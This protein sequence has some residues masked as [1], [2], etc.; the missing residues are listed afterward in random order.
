MTEFREK[1]VPYLA[2]ENCMARLER[3]NRRAWMVVVILI[4]A[5]LVTNFGWIYYEANHTHSNN[6]TQDIDI[7]TEGNVSEIGNGK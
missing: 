7:T 2:H 1:D 5:L 4:I 3:T 6:T